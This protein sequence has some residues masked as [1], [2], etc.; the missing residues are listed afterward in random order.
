MEYLKLS[1]SN[2]I[3]IDFSILVTFSKQF[4]KLKYLIID[5]SCSFNGLVSILCHTPQLYHLTCQRLFELDN[6]INNELSIK[7]SKLIHISIHQ[8]DVTFDNFEMLIK[9]ISSDLQT[10]RISMDSD[11]NYLDA[12]RWERLIANHIRNLHK[13]DLK[14]TG[15]VDKRF[16]GVD[17]E[18]SI[19]QFTSAFWIERGWCLEVEIN[20][21]E[22]IYWIHPSRYTDEGKSPTVKSL[23]KSDSGL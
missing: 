9:N 2:D 11:Q 22:T 8:C 4:S 12:S 17:F 7:L 14:Y 21:Y 19:I 23:F 1:F 16:N 20:H 15:N 6:N 10:L 3:K 18:T 13:I 5:H